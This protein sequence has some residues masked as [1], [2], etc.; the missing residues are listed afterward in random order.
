MQVKNQPYM[1][2]L[3]DSKLR[4][5]W[6][7]CLLSPCLFNSH[8]EKCQTGWVTSWN[9]DCQEKYQQPEICRWH[10]SKGRKWKGTKQP[11]MS[12]KGESEKA[13]LKLNIKKLRSW[14]PVPSLHGKHKVK[15]WKQWQIF[16]S[17]PLK[18]LQMV[19]AAMKLEDDSFSAGKLWQ[20]SC[21][22][23]QR[24]HSANKGPYSQVYVFPVVMYRSECWTIKKAE[25][26]RIDAFDLRC[27]RRLL[28]VPWTAR[29]SN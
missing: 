2:Q 4:R 19:T 11:L 13:S 20:T 27:W 16:S 1:E 7:G 22:K 29:R 15:R 5:V 17:W 28:R 12:M 23:K 8:H 24:H 26:Q 9:Q 10:H 21:I 3:T 25:S 14:H 6:Q 18:S